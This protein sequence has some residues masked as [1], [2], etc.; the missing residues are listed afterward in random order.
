[1]LITRGSDNN[2][3]QWLLQSSL[4]LVLLPSVY[5]VLVSVSVQYSALL[6]LELLETQLYE[7]NCSHTL[8]LGSLLLKLQ[9][10]SLLWLAS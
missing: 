9:G 10:Y 6:S 5:Q 1:M 2:K 7:D 3:K 8:F 4:V